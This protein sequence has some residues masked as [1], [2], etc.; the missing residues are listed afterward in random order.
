M[1]D[2]EPWKVCGVK[3][4]REVGSSRLGS[5]FATPT[6]KLKVP[7]DDTQNHSTQEVI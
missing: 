2:V 1:C 7:V 4:W 5:I 3:G 6:W